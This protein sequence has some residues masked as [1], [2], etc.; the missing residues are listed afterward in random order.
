MSNWKNEV[1]A[2]NSLAGKGLYM[3][4]LREME[5]KSRKLIS[6]SEHPTVFFVLE[7]I[8]S[9]LIRRM[10]DERLVTSEEYN[11]VQSRLAGPI[12]DLLTSV[13][14]DMGNEMVVER[15]DNVVREFLR[16]WSCL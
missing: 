10:W 13:Q 12:Q 4:N 15:L 3:D 8:S 6:S 1:Q 11:Y 16:V 9:D 14:S 5:D 2:L 7:T